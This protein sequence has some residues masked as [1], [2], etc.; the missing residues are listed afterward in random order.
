[1]RTTLKNPGMATPLD[2]P[3]S[4]ILHPEI[5]NIVHRVVD[6]P[7][8]RTTVLH[9]RDIYRELAVLLDEF[10]GAI[11]RVHQPETIPVTSLLVGDLPVLLGNDGH[12]CMVRIQECHDNSVGRLVRLGERRIVPLVLDL[13][14]ASI[15]LQD[16]R[17]RHPGR[18]H[19]RRNC[20]PMS[21]VNHDR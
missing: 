3:G 13:E 17:S 9:Q 14:I 4:G 1:M 6:H 19:Q 10:L 5:K 8:N 12:P 18:V 11:K 16:L 2:P 20:H 21:F 15:H 7:E